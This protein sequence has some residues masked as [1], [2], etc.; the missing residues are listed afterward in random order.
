MKI[1]IFTLLIAVLFVASP[2]IGQTDKDKAAKL[3][4]EA[5]E[6]MDNGKIKESIDLLEQAQ[7]LDP[8]EPTITY[9]IGYAYYID[10][11]Y[12]AAIKHLK[13][14][15][16]HKGANDRYFQLLGNSYD[17][18]GEREKAMETYDEGLVKFPKSGKLYLERGIIFLAD[19]KYNDAAGSFE[20]GIEVNPEHSSNYYWAA[21]IYCNSSE[22]V[23]GMLYGEIFLNLE[24]NS[25]R[26]AEISKLLYDTY[27]NAIKFTDTGTLISFSKMN[28]I[29]I[30]DDPTDIKFPFPMM[31]YE[32]GMA[33]A[34]AALEVNKKKKEIT[35]P[36][37]DFIRTNFLDIY[38]EKKHET[39]YPNILFEFQQTIQK[40]G[41]FEA[42]NY[43]ILM[44]GDEDAFDKW[45]TANENKWS[46]FVDWFNKNQIL[47][48]DAHK[49]FRA[50]Y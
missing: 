5:I 8:D 1:R 32:P 30:G 38:Y 26:T 2:I 12:K 37:L 9:E 6:L 47:V 39:K 16:N 23:W 50:Q 10:K 44:K 21:K 33:L 29:T 48:N 46:A 34:V 28:T 11:Q 25:K 35:L 40:K 14:V 43:W 42:Y 13:K 36:T 45:R 15:I 49:F 17:M 3:T 22:R 31:V 41:H 20:K 4:Q 19:E 24:R 18:D 27:V 7:K